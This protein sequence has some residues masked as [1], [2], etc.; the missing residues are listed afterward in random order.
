[1]TEVTSTAAPRNG[2]SVLRTLLLIGA[3]F[4]IGVLVTTVAALLIRWVT[5]DSRSGL[6][7]S[8]VVRDDIAAFANDS[9]PSRG[10]CGDRLGC[11]EGV[12]GEGVSLYRY[13][14]LDLARQAVIYN[15]TDFYRSDRLVIEFDDSV[16]PDERFELLQLVEGTFTGSSD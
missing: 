11:V 9:A 14:S 13:R 1:M 8:D 2:N 12:V 5:D 10:A 3:A 6:T 16:T 15:D 7:L 4:L